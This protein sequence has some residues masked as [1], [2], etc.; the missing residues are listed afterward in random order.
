MVT[1]TIQD[2]LRNIR[3]IEILS[4]QECRRACA[5]VDELRSSWIP[6]SDEAPFFSLGVAGYL[7]AA[8]GRFESYQR[9]AA[10][11]NPLLD[12]HFQWLFVRL[13]EAMSH[14]Y[15]TP[16]AYDR[17]LA[18]PGFH[19]FLAHEA[20][21]KAAGRVH[22]DLQFDDMDWQACNY[23]QVEPSTQLSLT[24]PLELPPE[25]AGLN[26]WKANHLELAQLSPEER[27]RHMAEN[28]RP[29]Y[30]E[31]RLGHLVLHTGFWLHQI[32]PA[33]HLDG[34]DRRITLQAHSIATD[35]GNVLY[36]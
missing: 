14:A 22:F 20:F 19:I 21:L 3:E 27:K 25:G 1:N 7:D 35:K 23:G 11:L 31:Y 32:A 6:R 33:R 4:P 9:R 10:Q 15:G 34:D 18:L 26:L 16:F 17:Q 2:H 24:L 36:W 13:A 30:H 12:E 28:R 5:A 29:A 8:G